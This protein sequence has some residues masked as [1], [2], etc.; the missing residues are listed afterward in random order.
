MRGV[1]Q[2][3]PQFSPDD[4]NESCNESREE[5]SLPITECYGCSA[6]QT[7]RPVDPGTMI[8]VGRHSYEVVMEDLEATLSGLKENV[9]RYHRGTLS[10][11]LPSAWLD[12][13]ARV[14]I[15]VCFSRNGHLVAAS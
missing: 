1:T 11:A 15:T 9:S 12:R 10:S 8:D 7:I 6:D 3:L 5:T 13:N 14:G 2:G 4:G